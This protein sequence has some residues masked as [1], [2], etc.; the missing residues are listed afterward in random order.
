M[1]DAVTSA[2]VELITG[3]AKAVPPV[4]PDEPVVT[5]ETGL[6]PVGLGLLGG[7][8]GLLALAA[9]ATAG[10][11]VVAAGSFYALNT[12]EF[13][14]DLKSTALTVGAPALIVAGASVLGMVVGAGLA[15]SGAIVLSGVLE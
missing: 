4:E 2:V 7:G 15:G 6:S 12:K 8:G 5:E 11:A 13:A 10:G 14:P 1:V 9:V 3:T